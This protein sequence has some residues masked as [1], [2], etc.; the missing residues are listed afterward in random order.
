[1]H[2]VSAPWDELIIASVLQQEWKGLLKAGI[3]IF[4]LS[5]NSMCLNKKK[6]S[7]RS[8]GSFNLV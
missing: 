5:S 4:S 7:S 2:C 1:M 6:G 3:M 8:A